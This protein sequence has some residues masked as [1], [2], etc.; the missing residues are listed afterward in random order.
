ML[1]GQALAEITDFGRGADEGGLE[2]G[3]GVKA[4]LKA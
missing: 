1:G 3:G 2:L 4:E